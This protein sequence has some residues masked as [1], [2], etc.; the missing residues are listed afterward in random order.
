MQVIYNR[1]LSI[2]V[3]T[4]SNCS[5]AV[6]GDSAQFSRDS[7]TEFHELVCVLPPRSP[8]VKKKIN[9]LLL[10]RLVMEPTLK[11]RFSPL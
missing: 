5:L 2:I 10:T 3:K 11:C 8:L 1:R 7:T 9:L 6:G 4:L